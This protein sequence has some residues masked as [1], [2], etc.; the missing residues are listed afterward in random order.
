MLAKSD[1]FCGEDSGELAQALKVAAPPITA[2]PLRNSRRDFD[3]FCDI[4]DS[5]FRVS[6]LVSDFA[7]FWNEGEGGDI[8]NLTT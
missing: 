6:Q 1:E 7:I 3:L 4:D 8:N 2:A 5:L